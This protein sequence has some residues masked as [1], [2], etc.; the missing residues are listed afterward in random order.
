MLKCAWSSVACAEMCMHGAVACACHQNVGLTGSIAQLKDTHLARS[1]DTKSI[2]EH[3]TVLNNEAV[4]QVGPGAVSV[5]TQ[6]DF[7]VL[8]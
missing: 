3:F 5:A 4:W 8:C 1:Y 7:L 2:L 6:D